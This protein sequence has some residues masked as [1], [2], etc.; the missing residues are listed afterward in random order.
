MVEGIYE[1]VR[2]K[3]RDGQFWNFRIFCYYG[4]LVKKLQSFLFFKLGQCRYTWVMFMYSLRKDI[5][6]F[7]GIGGNRC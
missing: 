3:Y 4:F 1:G 2:V 6:F 7:K 5:F